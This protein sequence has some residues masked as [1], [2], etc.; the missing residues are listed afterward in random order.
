MTIQEYH[1]E[2]SKRNRGKEAASEHDLQVICVR[3]FR[4][5]FRAY[6]KLLFAIPNGGYRL[7]TT[8]RMM[9]AEGELPGVPDIQ[10]AVPRNGYHGL[11]IEMKNGKAG[12]LSDHQ[13]EMIALLEEQGYACAVCH[14]LDEFMTTVEEYMK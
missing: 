6:E 11:F 10:L 1:K 13:K 8:A 12:R 14:T 7:K 2:M 5:K 9:R 3:W 4:V